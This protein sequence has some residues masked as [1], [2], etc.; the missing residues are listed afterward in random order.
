MA[1][2]HGEVEGAVDLP[3]DRR[4][5][6]RPRTDRRAVVATVAVVAS[7]LVLAVVVYWD[8]WSTGAAGRLQAGGDQFNT[9]WFLRWIPFALLHGHNP[10]F[11]TFGNTPFGVNLL[12]NT[13]VPL[14]GA[15]G[16]PVTLLFGPIATYNVLL[17]LALAGSAT[18]GYALIRRFVVRRPA[19]WVG[20]LVYG[21]SPY[22]IAQS[23]GGHLNLTFVVLPP[24]ILLTGHQLCRPGATDR[25]RWAVVLGLLA[26]AQYFVSSEVLVSTAVISAVCVVAAALAGGSTVRSRLRAAVPTG[27]WAAVIA[28]VLLAYPVWFTL[29]GPGHINGA[30]QLVPQAYRADLLGPLVP[31]VYMA[32]APAGLVRIA[33]GFANNTAENGSYLGITLVVALAVA[34]VWLWRRSVVLRVA[35]IGGAAAFILS[36]GGALAVHRKPGALLTG[37]PLPERLFTKLPLLS[38]TVPVRYSLYVALFAGLI[39][40]LLL[41]R[42]AAARIPVARTP[43]AR[44]VLPAVVAVLCLVPLVPDLPLAGITNPAV[45]AY[46]SSSSLTSTPAGAVTLLYPYPSSSVPNGQLW[47]AVADMHFK[48]VGGYF[49]VPDGPEGHIGFSPVV[50]YGAD[51]LTARTLISLYDGD[52]PPE[53][54]GLRLALLAQL[55]AWRVS[56]IVASFGGVPDPARSLAFLTWMAGR[57][58]VH[59]VDVDLWRRP[60]S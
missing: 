1:A 45:P 9:V 2:M 6:H 12:T 41:D 53:T 35:A 8:A 59:D 42:L 25:R 27:A 40:A 4:P 43:M 19:A 32:L 44:A 17:T 54:T 7:Y 5:D 55:R 33:D 52:P 13:S 11:T 22:Q 48:S 29:R 15:V 50:S 34:T 60:T 18:A 23:N 14:L 20:G 36:M 37:L 51:T 10:F 56:S 26:T 21:F 58:P 28:V 16:T 49:L 46:F 39:L 38:N 31:N 47:Q 30:I 3:S 24:L 57:P